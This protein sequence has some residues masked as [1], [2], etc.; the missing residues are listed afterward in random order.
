MIKLNFST[1]GHEEGLHSSQINNLKNFFKNSDIEIS[2]SRNY[3]NGAINFIFEGWSAYREDEVKKF[4]NYKGKKGIVFTESI[5]RSKK[6]S[7][8]FCTMN[9]F[10][11]KKD[12]L[13][14]QFYLIYLHYKIALIRFFN[15]IRS[16]IS[17]DMQLLKKKIY[18]KNINNQKIK[19]ISLFFLKL[20]LKIKLILIKILNFSRCLYHFDNNNFYHRF[21]LGFEGMFK[22]V[23]NRTFSQIHKF[24]YAINFGFDDDRSFLLKKECIFF[25]LPYLYTENNIKKKIDIIDILKSKEYDFLF[26][27]RITRKRKLILDKIKEKFPSSVIINSEVNFASSEELSNYIKKSKYIINLKQYYNQNFISSAKVFEGLDYNVPNIVDIE[28]N[29]KINPHILK[30]IIFR[31]NFRDLDNLQSYVDEY[32]ENLI[33]FRKSMHEFVELNQNKKAFILNLIKKNY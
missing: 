13:I 5:S 9:N 14:N 22:E 3:L 19:I 11:F 10:S 26:F 25:C 1:I 7:N 32:Q 8:K 18:S 29:E 15:F 31:F 23:F 21:I 6:L 16:D 30:N 20:N 4:L 27:G 17:S 28:D 12:T 33:K 2:F 24:D